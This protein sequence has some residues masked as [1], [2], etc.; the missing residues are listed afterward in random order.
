MTKT[1]GFGLRD[2][3]T[4]GFGLRK[5]VRKGMTLIEVILAIVILSVTMLGLERFIQE[6]QHTTSDSTTQYLAS[7]LATQQIETIKAFTS[8]STLVSTYNGLVE[9]FASNPVY[10]GF[11]RTTTAVRCSG[12]PDGTNDYITV[13]VTVTGNSMTAA[14]TKTTV[15]AAF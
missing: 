3:R 2:G 12:C 6:F 10:K 9:T 15:I 11:T 5:A 4:A 1:A 13:T 8:Y 14:K 7:D